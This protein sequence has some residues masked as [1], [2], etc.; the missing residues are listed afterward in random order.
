MA[1]IPPG[2]GFFVEA[3]RPMVLRKDRPD[4]VVA[5]LQLENLL[6]ERNGLP[7]EIVASPVELCD[8]EVEPACLL[9]FASHRAQVG[10]FVLQPDVGRTLTDLLPEIVQL[11]TSSCAA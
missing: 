6:V 11:H 9:H 10:E 4:L 5:R 2:P 7:D 3:E 1:V 8:L